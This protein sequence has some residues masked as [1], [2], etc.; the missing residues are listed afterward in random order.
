MR[1]VTR[2]C[3]SLITL[4]DDDLYAVCRSLMSTFSEMR[5]RTSRLT[6]GSAR[7]HLSALCSKKWETRRRGY[8]VAVV[9]KQISCSLGLLPY[10]NIIIPQ[11]YALACFVGRPITIS[12][13]LLAMIICT[14]VYFLTVYFNSR[15]VTIT[16]SDVVFIFS[17]LQTDY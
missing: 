8:P 11:A 13:Q 7:S 4:T 12:T 17:T 15:S 2:N 1:Y 9:S 14:I 16:P 5:W 6:P 10:V 3:R